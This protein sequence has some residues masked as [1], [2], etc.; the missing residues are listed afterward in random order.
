MELDIALKDLSGDPICERFENGMEL[1]DCTDS[2]MEMIYDEI[3]RKTPMNYTIFKS[4]I[5]EIGQ[6]RIEIYESAR[7]FKMNPVWCGTFNRIPDE[8][9]RRRYAFI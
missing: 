3:C 1:D 5:E 9:M 6:W 7:D 8:E 2:D 4:F